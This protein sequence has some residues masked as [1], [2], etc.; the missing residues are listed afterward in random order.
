MQTI[1]GYCFVLLATLCWSMI[2]PIG[3]FPLSVGV[4]PLE[5]AFWRACFGFIFFLTHAGLTNKWRVPKRMAVTFALFGI[6]GVAC[7]FLTYMVGVKGA[8]S[9]MT[10]VLQNGS[11]PVFVAF[12]AVLLFKE[13][14]S[15]WRIIALALAVVGVSLVCISGGGLA[16][17]AAWWGVASGIASGL[18]YSLHFCFGKKFLANYSPVTMYMYILPAGALFMFPFIDFMPDKTLETWGWLALFGLVT[19]WGGYWAYCEGL[20]R[21][22]ITK[23]G[24]LITFEPLIAAF[25][26]W[27]WWDENFSLLGWIGAAAIIFGIVLTT[28]DKPK[29]E[30]PACCQNKGEDC[31]PPSVESDA[32]TANL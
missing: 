6:P 22:E 14:L 31:P 12:W 19:V 4:T 26:S 23:V 10:S 28:L 8:G 16:E 15:H 13:H 32:G 25:F 21:L 30:K 1:L 20:R 3:R 17:G 18:C 29:K 2:G 27:L 9:A 7:L 5:T 11:A 24:V